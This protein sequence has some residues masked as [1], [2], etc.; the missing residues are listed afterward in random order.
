[1]LSGRAEGIRVLAL[2][3]D[4]TLRVKPDIPVARSIRLWLVPSVPEAC[5]R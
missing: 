3:D 1:M 4:Y 5:F 2:N